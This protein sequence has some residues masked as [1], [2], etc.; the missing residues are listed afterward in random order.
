LAKYLAK[1]GLKKGVIIAVNSDW[2]EES[3][4]TFKKYAEQAGIKIVNTIK[5]DEQTEEFVPIL[6]Q[7]RQAAPDFIFQASQLLNEQVAF[8]RAYRQLGL[9]VQLAGESTWTEDVP[10]KAGWNLVDG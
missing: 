5:Y 2:G 1:R 9:K 10:E 4:R 8:L 7:A 6:A 3:A